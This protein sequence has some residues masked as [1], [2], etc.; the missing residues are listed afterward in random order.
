MTHRAILAGRSDPSHAWSPRLSRLPGRLRA[1]EAPFPRFLTPRPDAV[2]N[3]TPNGTPQ[4]LTRPIRAPSVVLGIRTPVV[5][6]GDHEDPPATHPVGRFAMS[7][8]ERY[9]LD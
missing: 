5:A 1:R 4:T 7:Y 3:G 6:V 8:A 9:A 2:A